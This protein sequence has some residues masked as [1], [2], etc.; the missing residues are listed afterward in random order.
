M[1]NEHEC[2]G[3]C[4]FFDL[5]GRLCRRYPHPQPAVKPSHWCG[6]FVEEFPLKELSG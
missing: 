5:Y 6:E 1:S 2:C 4:K 3:K